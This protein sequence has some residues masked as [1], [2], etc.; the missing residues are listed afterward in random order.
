MSP[1]TLVFGKIGAGEELVIHS[2]V[3]E[4]GI[5]FGDGIEAGYFACNSGAIARVGL[6]ERQANLIIRS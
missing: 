2:H 1:S 5:I 6:A 3:P 4:N